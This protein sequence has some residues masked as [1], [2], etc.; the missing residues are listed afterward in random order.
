MCQINGNKGTTTNMCL[1]SKLK[2]PFMQLQSLQSYKQ[3][4]IPVQSITKIKIFG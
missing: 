2:L 1:T 3:S 4:S